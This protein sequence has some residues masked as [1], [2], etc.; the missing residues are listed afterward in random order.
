MSTAAVLLG[1]GSPDP[2]GRA[3]LGE[4]RALVGRRLGLDV[5]LGVL[6]FPGPGLPAVEEALAAAGDRAR[7]AA[8]PLILFDGLHG[9]HDLPAAA[10]GATA[11]LGVEVR[12]GAALGRDPALI[13]LATARAAELRPASG[14]LL[15]FVGRGSSEPLARAQTEQVAAM[16]AGALGL[17]HAVCYTGISRPSL[18]D[19]IALALSRA[20]RR[21]LAL[22][23][24]LHTG[25]LVRRVGE[26]LG[27]AAAGDGVALAVLPHLGNAPQVVDLVASRLEALLG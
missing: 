10:A 13:E 2:A 26:V 18:A 3:E 12:L 1:H 24:L 11:R 22:P 25:V 21:I 16:V 6:E 7:I 27:P 8:Q 5:G 14:D 23:Y 4:L 17:D 9:R 19:G 15:L 20:P